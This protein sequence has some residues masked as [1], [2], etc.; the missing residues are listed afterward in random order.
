MN[1]AVTPPVPEEAEVDGRSVRRFLDGVERSSGRARAAA[2]TALAERGAASPDDGEWYPFAALLAAVEA[3]GERAGGEALAA[4]GR[5][6]GAALSPVAVTVPEALKALDDA[7]RRHHRGAAGGYAFRQIG[8][9]DGRVECSTPYPCVFDCA[10]V[11]CVAESAADGV[12]CLSEAST[13]RADGATRCT[14]ELTW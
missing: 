1:A 5:H 14:Y 6:C 3:V 7:Y 8:L 9:R 12:V 10:V 4:A 11:A 13:C 2:E